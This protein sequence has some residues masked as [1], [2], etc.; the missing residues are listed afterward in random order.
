[1]N[2]IYTA[3]CWF[4]TSSNILILLS[5]F[6]QIRFE[7]CWLHCSKC[8]ILVLLR[9]Q[10]TKNLTAFLLDI[11]Y[12]MQGDDLYS[13][14]RPTLQMLYSYMCADAVSSWGVGYTPACS[15]VRFCQNGLGSLGSLVCAA[16]LA[17]GDTGCAGSAVRSYQ[18]WHWWVSSLVVRWR[19][20]R[21]RRRGRGK[22]RM[23][24]G[25]KGEEDKKKGRRSRRR[26]G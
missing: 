11:M 7:S 21:I 22:R 10:D 1:M 3:C 19:G 25:A 2:Y 16:G 9:Y 8:R 13:F 24:E 5:Q 20:R 4:P 14:L 12:F 23:G 15:D 26:R 17:P 6:W 18:V